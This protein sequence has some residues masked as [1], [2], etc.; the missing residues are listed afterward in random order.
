MAAAAALFLTFASPARAEVGATISLLSEA[1]LRG[2]SM[3]A[4]NPVG[5]LDLSFDHRDGFYLGLS[6]SAV[7][8]PGRGLKPLSLSENVGFAKRLKSGPTVDVGIVNSY[9]T[10][11]SGRYRTLSYS[12][13]YVGLI[14]RNLASRVYVSPNYFY[15]GVWTVYGEL[16]TAVR[17]AG[18]LRLTAHVGALAQLRGPA[19]SKPHYDWR[20]GAAHDIGPFSAQLSLSGGGPGRDYYEDSTRSRTAVVLGLSYIL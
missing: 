1:R 19:G 3:S 8:H 18:K 7:V 12:E 13:A 20:I 15:P 14:G 4:G 17:P 10:R 11:H 9:Y 6:A 2:Y 5:Q 16:D